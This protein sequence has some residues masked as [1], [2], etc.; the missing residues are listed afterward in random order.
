[1]GTLSTA[2]RR[3]LV[4]IM[5]T[6]PQRLT[7][8]SLLGTGIDFGDFAL[9]TMLKGGGVDGIKAPNVIHPDSFIVIKPAHLSRKNLDKGGASKNG[10]RSNKGLVSPIATPAKRGDVG[11]FG[12]GKNPI[13]NSNISKNIGPNPNTKHQP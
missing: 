2:L 1:M 11:Q 10:G 12:D 8:L 9:E 4:S 7:A 3:V 5:K 13:K 6:F